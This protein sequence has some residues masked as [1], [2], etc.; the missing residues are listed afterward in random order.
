LA[1]VEI[2]HLRY[3]VAVAD[4][5]NFGH[6]AGRLQIAQPAL[7]P[8]I[9]SLETELGVRLFDRTKRHVVLTEAASVLLAETDATLSRSDQARARI[10]QVSVGARRSTVRI[11]M[12][13]NWEVRVELVTGLHQR[14]PNVVVGLEVLPRRL[15][16][17]PLNV[18]SWSLVWCGPPR[19]LAAYH[20]DCLQRTRTSQL[21]NMSAL[22]AGS[23]RPSTQTAFWAHFVQSATISE[24]GVTGWQL[25]F[26]G[27]CW[28]HDTPAAER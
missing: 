15:C 26:G 21:A 24:S 1:D 10:H 19:W 23:T 22:C 5:L 2:R 12:F 4:E 7:S 9:R 13:P 27:I 14:M 25:P 18:A 6:A 28:S 11:A 8:Q 20:G 3:F 16:C 17:T